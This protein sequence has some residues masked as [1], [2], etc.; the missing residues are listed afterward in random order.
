MGLCFAAAKICNVAEKTKALWNARSKKN[1]RS[2]KPH[3]VDASRTHK[4]AKLHENN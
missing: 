4:D 3:T 2:E 1:S